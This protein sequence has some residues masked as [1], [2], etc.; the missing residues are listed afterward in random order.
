[1]YQN[2]ISYLYE[3][4]HVSGD[5]PPITCSE[6]SFRVCVS[7][8]G[9]SE[10]LKS[11]APRSQLGSCAT[12]KELKYGFNFLTYLRSRIRLVVL[13]SVFVNAVSCQR[14]HTYVYLYTNVYAWCVQILIL[15]PWHRIH[16]FYFSRDDWLTRQAN[17]SA[18]A[19]IQGAKWQIF[20]LVY[21]RWREED[22]GG[23]TASQ[24]RWPK[25]M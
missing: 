4:Q 9:W 10:N 15:F 5:T 11:E 23:M 24:K 16:K 13:I 21:I 18:H 12:E 7:Y 22:E 6:Q 2:F 3:A 17:L 25:V 14:M 1:M 20:T 19:G 8:C